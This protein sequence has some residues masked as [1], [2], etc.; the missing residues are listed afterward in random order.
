MDRFI[1]DLRR[2]THQ[3]KERC[4]GFGGVTLCYSPRNPRRHN[5]GDVLECDRQLLVHWRNFASAL[6]SY[7]EYI[8][9]QEKSS[10]AASMKGEGWWISNI[11]VPKDLRDL[12]EPILNSRN[13]RTLILDRNEFGDHQGVGFLCSIIEKNPYLK[14]VS[15]HNN[16]MED[17]N[18]IRRFC[19]AVSKHSSLEHLT[20]ENVGLGGYTI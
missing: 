3:L 16:L 12:L 8:E 14:R 1:G 11:Q 17:M 9:P 6:R 4:H 10:T 15:F 20:L 2:S 13:V 5:E 19:G 18:D 7:D